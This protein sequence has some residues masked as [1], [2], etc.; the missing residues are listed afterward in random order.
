MMLPTIKNLILI[1]TLG[2]TGTAYAVGAGFY[3][4]G[5]LGQ[6]NIHNKAKTVEI[7]SGSSSVT[8]TN[9]GIGERIFVGYQFDDYIGIEAGGIHYA[10]STYK[11][12]NGCSNPRTQQN[13]IDFLGKFSYPFSS[14]GVDLFAKA[15]FAYVNSYNTGTLDSGNLS[16]CGC[17]NTSK[18]S[19][20]P[21]AGFGVSYDITQ[22]WVA[23]F[24]FNRMF[25]GSTIQT[26]DFI[27]LGISYHIVDKYCGQFLC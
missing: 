1:A 7:N 11:V 8:P 21:A 5:Q 24:S 23:D 12:S 9:K 6:T 25:S 16:S 14:I 17:T 4:G 27:A 26:S 18:Y 20:R 15:G 19:A 2:I 10:D 22:N 13:A 3:L